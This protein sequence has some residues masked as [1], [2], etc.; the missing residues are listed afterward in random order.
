M[1]K[2][3]ELLAPAGSFDSLRAAID[4]GADAVYFGGT[5]AN[6]RNSAKNFSGDEIS[7]AVN[8]LHG[9]GRLAYITLN[10]LH[11]DRE[12]NAG[13]APD[14]NNDS[15]LKFAEECYVCGADAFIIQDI[16]LS[17]IIRKY[18][19]GI[20]LHASTQA[21]GHN[22]S[23]S[24]KLAELGFSRMVAAREIDRGN[25]RY[26][27]DN[28]PVEIEMFAHGALCSSHSGRCFMSLA[29]GGAR[30]ANRGTCAQPCRLKYNGGYALSLKDL[31][32]AGHIEEIIKLAPAGLKIEGRMKSSEYVY[33]VCRIYRTCLDENRNASKREI[34]FLAGIFSRQGFT[35][36]YFTKN[37]GIDM[38]GVR[39]E[40]NKRESLKYKSAFEF[41]K[42]AEASKPQSPLF[43][44]GQPPRKRLTGDYNLPK[45]KNIKMNPKLVLIFNSPGKLEEV[46]DYI[47]TEKN[48]EIL[49]RIYKIFTPPETK[50][51]PE[52]SEIS[53]IKPPY[54]IFDDERE[55]IV[56]SIKNSGSKCVLIDN[57]GHI[58]L[59]EESGLELFGNFGLNAV[60]SYT[61]E[62]YKKLGFKNIILSP[63]LNFAQI[64]D[65]NKSLNCG[66]IA[67]GRTHIMISENCLM[68]NA[69]VKCGGDFYLKD[70]T[71]AEFL[72]K[73]DGNLSCRNIIYNSIPVYLADKKEL[74]KNLGLFF[75]VL[76]FTDENPAQIK[77]IIKDYALN[78]TENINPPKK[79]TRGYKNN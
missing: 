5:F 37:T 57:I 28:S 69:G 44:R 45:S 4:G 42:E 32:L 61:L 25:L 26:L 46:Y 71:G 58:D 76:N 40:E 33:N 38:Y 49:K 63:E 78:N 36:G 47:R 41:E 43:Q 48:G 20:K 34:D 22:L 7:R 56:E 1:R 35:D 59:A 79:F 19:P 50:I 8:L 16:G 65:L 75:I 73:R 55:K 11:A 54:V 30:S 3:P 74:Y 51:M 52:L 2:I 72:I 29:L 77:K 6:A 62:E 23:A 68:K 66:I 18:F 64:R 21:A 12:L 53:G 67:Y 9:N 17:Q 31:C 39:T 70:R 13:F 15:L 27:L 60:N 14:K 10:I 24:K